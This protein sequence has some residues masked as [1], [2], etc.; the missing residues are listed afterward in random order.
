[1]ADEKKTTD[2]L[3]PVDMFVYELGKAYER[4]D[5]YIM[6]ATGQNPRKWAATSWWFTQYDGNTQ[7]KNKALYWRENAERVWDC[8]GMAE[9]IYKDYSGIDINTRARYNYAQWCSLKGAGMIPKECRMPGAAVFW[10]NTA[11]D[12]T[13]VA[14]L[15]APVKPD[16]FSGDWY[17]IEARGVLNGVVKTKL[18]ARKPNYW[19]LM[20]K[21]FDYSAYMPDDEV[22]FEYT[23][24]ETVYHLG[25]RNLSYGSEGDDVKELQTMLIELGYDCGIYGADGTFSDSTDISVRAFQKAKKL[26]VDGIVGPLTTQA[27]EKAIAAT[28]KPVT[29]PKKVVVT[30]GSV[31]VRTAPNV[32]KGKMLG[33]VHKGEEFSYQ[34]QTSEDG[35][36]LIDWNNHNAWISGRYSALKK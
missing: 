3:M 33:I 12:I 14:Y 24:E 7:Q 8:N 19:G 1:M 5:G 16:D 28:E 9:G 20:D 21:Y 6:G 18:S 11:A 13:H 34:G 4:N 25:D 22:P 23:Y 31:Y 27:L 29:N 32:E 15:Y 26:E 30:G 35:W 17:L 36:N 2:V 10:G